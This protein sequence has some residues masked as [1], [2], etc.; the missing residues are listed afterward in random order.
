MAAVSLEISG[1]ITRTPRSPST[2]VM[3]DRSKPRIW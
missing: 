2:I 1:S 3:F